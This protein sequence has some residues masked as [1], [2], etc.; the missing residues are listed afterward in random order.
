MRWLLGP[1]RPPQE[2]IQG[3]L[4]LTRILLTHQRIAILEEVLEQ[5]MKIVAMTGYLGSLRVMW[6]HDGHNITQLQ[7]HIYVLTD[8]IQDLNLPSGGRP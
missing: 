8:K 6:P 5:A 4:P 7:G 2:F 3:I 1:K